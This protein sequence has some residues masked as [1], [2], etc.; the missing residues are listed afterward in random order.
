MKCE[1]LE[2][3]IDDFAWVT[4]I[5]V[6][7]IWSYHHFLYWY[8]Y[9]K[10]TVRCA[11]IW[12]LMYLYLKCHLAPWWYIHP[13]SKELLAWD[14]CIRLA[15][16]DASMTQWKTKFGGL[17]WILP[18]SGVRCYVCGYHLL[19]FHLLSI[20]KIMLFLTQHFLWL[21]FCIN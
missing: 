3:E 20:M 2:K 18:L 11:I 5:S 15:V 17:V 14:P 4:W 12:S 7:F 8:A 10:D 13:S 1:H 21:M 16:C 19:Q 6:V 9:E